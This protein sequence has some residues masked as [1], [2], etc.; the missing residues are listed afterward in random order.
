MRMFAAIS[1]LALTI[2]LAHSQQTQ[3]PTD[4]PQESTSGRAVS[5]EDA[6]ALRQDLQRMKSLVYQMERNLASITSAQDPLKHQFQLEID[7]WQIEIG[8]MERRLGAAAEQK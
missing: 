1:L 6:Q 3:K 2:P 5:A 8:S 4:P 7:M